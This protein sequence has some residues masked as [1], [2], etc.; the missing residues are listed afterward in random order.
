VIPEQII[1]ISRGITVHT[2]QKATENPNQISWYP[3]K[4]SNSTHTT[5]IP[6]VLSLY[7]PVQQL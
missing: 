3:N 5:Y 4:D 6:R 2:L 1:F 7:W